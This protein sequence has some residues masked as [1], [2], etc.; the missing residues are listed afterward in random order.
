M[1][2]QFL[3][4]INSPDDLK[5]LNNDDLVTLCDEIR[6]CILNT[7]SE[8][9]G[10]LASNLGSVE[11]TIAIH[12]VFNS[13]NDSI[14]FD[15]GHQCYTHKLLTGRFSNFSTLRKTNGISGFTRPDESE[16]DVVI[17]GHSSTSISSAEGI[18]VANELLQK[19]GYSIAVIGDGALTGGMAYEAMINARKKDK[20]LIVILNDNKMSISKSRG[21]LA[22]HLG[23]IR[24]RKKYHKFKTGVERFL[25][26]IPLVGHALRSFV[27][28]LKAALKNSIY[29]SNIFESLGFY[30]MGPV[31][32]HNL[33]IITDL[34]EIAKDESRPVLIHVKTV[35][36]KGYSF[37]ETNP[38]IYHGVAKFDKTCGVTACN[39]ENFSS[40]FGDELIKLA[41][42]DSKIVAV[43]AAMPD[44]TGLKEFANKFKSRFFDVGIAEQHAVTFSAALA[45]SGLKPVFAVYS[46]FLQRAYD[47]IIHDAA[48][49][50]LPLTLAVDRA[51]FVGEDGETHQGLFDVS[52]L[53]SIPDV[54][55]FAPSNYNELRS[56]LKLRMENPV[57]VAAI[58]YPRGKQYHNHFETEFNGEEFKTFGSNDTAVVTYGTLFD[59]A[60][61]AKSELDAENKS[62]SVVKLNELTT[63][64]DD[65]ISKLKAFKR[66]IFFEEG[67][68]KGSV[69]ESLGCKLLCNNFNGEYEVYAVKSFVKQDSVNSQRVMHSLDEESIYKICK[70]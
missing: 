67:I 1:N 21:A 20:R 47:Q 6:D 66:I 26:K 40:V 36:G 8:N 12:K 48:I 56:M 38:D 60:M 7:V 18:S 22:K 35:K 39:T 59:L 42:N 46:T 54:K 32:G 62:I 63:L 19:N 27:F 43:T 3:N 25:I 5:K 64:S 37:A 45:K 53:S 11:L 33:S 17:S 4:N 52:F 41:E 24:A 31:D 15:V 65:L 58:R 28:K 29:D 34:L 30:Y 57:G 16:H 2:Y 61:N 9:G 10:H 44:G 23:K 49:A 68:A 14:I 55:I 69:A 50:K 51:G 70:R 13:P